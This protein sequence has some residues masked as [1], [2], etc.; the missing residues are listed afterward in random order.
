MKYRK[1]GAT[2]I[3]VSVIGIGTW[4]LGGEWGQ[5]FTPAEVE[6]IFDA[7]REAGVTLVDTAACYGPRESER[8]VG[9]AIRRDRERWVLATK[10]GLE[11]TG[12]MERS[13]DYS[14]EGMVRQLHESLRAL[15]TDYIDLFQV[16][17]VTPEVAADGRLWDALAEQKAK[18]L[19]RAIGVSIRFD[20][21]TLGPAGVVDAAQ[22][23]YNRLERTAE[24]ELFPLCRE[25]GMGVLARVPLASGLLSGKYQPGQAW[26]ATDVRA[27]RPAEELNRDILEAQRLAHEEVPPGVPMAQWA[28]AWCLGNPA[29]SAVIPGCKTVEQL[30]SN[31]AAADLEV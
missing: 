27:T 29:V 22:I 1:L 3:E 23:I 25:R 30:R 7:A 8:L 20:P 16:H 6:P 4:Q 14:P 9:R 21:A 12:W 11:Y 24:R 19:I 28:L 18:G 15:Q 31:A 17:S 10:F 5:E 26:A 2:G 13:K